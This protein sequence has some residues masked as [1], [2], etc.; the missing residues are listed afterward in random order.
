MDMFKQKLKSEIKSDIVDV[1]TIIKENFIIYNEYQ[2][3][4]IQRNKSYW[5][6]YRLYFNSPNWILEQNLLSISQTLNKIKNVED[7]LTVFIQD[8][9]LEYSNIFVCDTPENCFKLIK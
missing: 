2:H 3:V 9:S 4:F 7:L 6:I 1:T 8:S 5:C